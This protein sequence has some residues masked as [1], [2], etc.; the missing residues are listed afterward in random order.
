M[1]EIDRYQMGVEQPQPERI[2][3]PT[4]GRIDRPQPQQID[5]PQPDHIDPPRPDR[6]ID[7]VPPEKPSRKGAAESMGQL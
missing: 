7:Q 1:C 2:D 5:A 6:V 4:P 3:S